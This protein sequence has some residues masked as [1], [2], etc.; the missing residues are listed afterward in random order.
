MIG[1]EGCGHL[2][3][4]VNSEDLPQCAAYVSS[5]KLWKALAHGNFKRSSGLSCCRVFAAF[6]AS[7]AAVEG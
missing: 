4:L 7:R 1:V 2:N 6:F 5:G 3:T